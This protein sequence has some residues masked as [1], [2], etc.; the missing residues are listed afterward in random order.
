MLGA[1]S[2]RA[3]LSH[4]ALPRRFVPMIGRLI[5]PASHHRAMHD[6]VSSLFEVREGLGGDAP[7]LTGKLPGDHLRED[8]RRRRRGAG[9]G[10]LFS[11]FCH[12]GVGHLPRAQKI[13]GARTVRPKGF[14][15]VQRL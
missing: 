14:G 8:H 13:D 5:H 12:L 3:S 9:S 7:T 10:S 2:I 15:Y 11:L 1:L 4:R 6:L